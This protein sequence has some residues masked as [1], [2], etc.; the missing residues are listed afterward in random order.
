[1]GEREGK[2][3]NKCE[4]L[5]HLDQKR[6]SPELEEEEELRS[7]DESGEEVVMGEREGKMINE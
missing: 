1:M 6:L 2:I 5:K 4:M 3:L 7:R